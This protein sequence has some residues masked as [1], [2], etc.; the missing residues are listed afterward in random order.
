MDVHLTGFDIGEDFC[1]GLRTYQTDM[2][3]VVFSTPR[4]SKDH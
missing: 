3:L 1:E 4:N 2:L